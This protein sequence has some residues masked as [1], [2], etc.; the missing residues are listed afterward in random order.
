[1]MASDIPDAGAERVDLGQYC[2]DLE[3]HLCRRNGGHLIRIVGPAFEMVSGWYG[4]GVPLPI[5]QR[6]I[7]RLVER[8]AR[9]RRLGR[10]SGRRPVRIEACEPDVLEAFEEWRRAMGPLF[11]RA[12]DGGAETVHEVAGATAPTAETSRASLPEHLRRAL[13]RLT[14]IRAA[15]RYSPAF[16]GALDTAIDALD[17]MYDASRQARGARRA[18]M[19]EG[20]GDVDRR[21]IAAAR[22]WLSPL[23]SVRLDREATTR[24]APHREHMST[25]DYQRLHEAAVEKLVRNHLQLPVIKLNSR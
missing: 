6:G 11:A 19:L 22:A 3:A 15:A 12:A 5:A 2:R 10:R 4:R 1:M 25:D 20:L 8:R 18:A 7:D 21:L 23:E 14:S 13:L 16:E 9:D 17:A 24:L